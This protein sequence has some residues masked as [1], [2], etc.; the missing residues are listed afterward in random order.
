MFTLGPLEALFIVLVSL[1][2]FVFNRRGVLDPMTLLA[3]VGSLSVA[4]FFTPPDPA[5]TFLLSG[6]LMAVYFWARSRQTDKESKV[7]ELAPANESDLLEFDSAE[8]ADVKISD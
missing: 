2:L 7:S 4:S 8:S 1:I 3:I 6:V 5:S